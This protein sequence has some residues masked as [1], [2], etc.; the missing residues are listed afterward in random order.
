M[1]DAKMTQP[2][3]F[4]DRLKAAVGPDALTRQ[5][6]VLD[7]IGERVAGNAIDGIPSVFRTA[8]EGTW[9]PVL[10]GGTPMMLTSQLLAGF[11][12]TIAP[13]NAVKIMTTGKPQNIVRVLNDGATIKPKVESHSV[14][15]DGKT[16]TVKN[17]LHFKIGDRWAQKLSVTIPPRRWNRWTETLKAGAVKAAV[18]AVKRMLQR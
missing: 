13:P 17:Y 3:E 15:R 14:T 9:A 4:L 18:T 12:W 16:F 6:G 7:E 2:T 8:G 1:F 5:G 10:R 11:T